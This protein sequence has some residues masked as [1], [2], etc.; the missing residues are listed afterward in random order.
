MKGLTVVG[1]RRSHMHDHAT[2]LFTRIESIVYVSEEYLCLKDNRRKD[3]GPRVQCE[4]TGPQ[5][6]PWLIIDGRDYGARH[7]LH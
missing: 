1:K 2:Y 4:D 5:S 7:D 3:A 6:F